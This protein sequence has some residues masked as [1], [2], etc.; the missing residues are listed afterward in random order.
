MDGIALPP[1]S[2]MTMAMNA[3]GGGRSKLGMEMAKVR[4][5]IDFESPSVWIRLGR[6]GVFTGAW[7]GPETCA[8]FP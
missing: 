5:D 6:L 7:Y 3:Y 4:F 8:R 1:A 2:A